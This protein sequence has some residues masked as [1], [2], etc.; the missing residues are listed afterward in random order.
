MAAPSTMPVATSRL[1]A[2]STPI[3]S[4]AP[5]PMT[6]PAMNPVSGLSPK[7]KAPEPPVVATSVN[8]WPAKD[9]LRTTVKT[10]TTAE[11]TAVSAPMS[12]AVW[13]GALEKN[14]GSNRR[15]TRRQVTVNGG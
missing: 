2:R 11:T 10:P 13:T 9:W 12:A 6:P 14:P 15:C 5:P 3:I 8:A 4:M 1:R 7:R